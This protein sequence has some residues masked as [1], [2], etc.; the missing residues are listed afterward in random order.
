VGTLWQD[1]RYAFR[2]LRTHSGF[3][4]VAVLT[5]AL[6]IGANTAIFSVVNAVLLRPLPYADPGRLVTLWERSPRRGFEQE[7][8]TPP[9]FLDWREQ[10]RVFEN[11]AFWTGGGEFNLVTPD[12]V[13]KV[14]CAYALSNLFP[15]LRAGPLLGR[16]FL[17]EE[18]QRESNRV[19][20]LGYGYWQRR[21]AGDPSVIGRTITVDTYGRREY[22]IVGVMPP[23]FSFP[24][25]CEVWLPAGWNGIPTDR[26][27]GHWLEVIARLKPGVTL[28]QAQAEMN[29][30][31]A[32]LEQQYPDVLIGSQVAIVPLLEQT[33]GRNLRPALLVLWGVVAC[34]LLIACANVANL[35]LARAAVRRKEIAVRL[36]LGATRWQVI[37][38]L[39]TESVLLAMVGGVLGVLLA[40]WGLKVLV[41][42]G[43]N[44][45]PRLEGV[46]IDGR[47]L[48][49]TVLVS[50][51]TGVLFGLAPAWQASKPDVYETL[52]D[53]SRGMAGGL[54][55]SRLRSLLVV[56]E[57]ALSLVLLV[58]AGLMTRSFV[59]LIRIDRGFQPDHLLTAQLDFSISG[60]TTWVR[61]TATRPQ[62]TLQELMERIKHRPGVQS[63]AAV[64]WL[65]LTVGSARTQPIVIENHPPASSGD[66]LT[67]TFQGITPDY[68]RTLG[69]PLLAGRPFTES[70]VFEAPAVVIINETMAKRYFPNEN[71]VGQHL[72]MGGRTPG[73]IVGPNPNAR[74]PWSEIVGVVAD[75]KKLNLSAETVPEYYA[76]YWQ[77]PMQTPVIVVRTAADPANIAA[78][79]RGEVK[80]VNKNLPAPV[81]RTM[82]EI[83][84]D[85]VAQPRFH[86]LLV[87]LFG[88]VA[89]VL[90]ALGIY[91]VISYS[92]TQRTH[93]IGIRLALGA[94]GADILRLIVGQGM[95]LV[96]AGLLSGL[97]VASA[98]TRVMSGLLY[99][100]S[101]TDPATFA[102]TCLLLVGVALLA[103]YI[104]ARKAA[105][106]DPMIAL[107]HE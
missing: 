77:F 81:I 30:I 82:D 52:K 85:S 11:L 35:L 73:Q 75:M 51:L 23:G 96:A 38:Q 1:L 69:L 45:I 55:R 84:A 67:A 3:T 28:D 32:R 87:S 19:A 79:I 22:T 31:Q 44:H 68:F 72:A 14:K 97:A 13:E 74:S 26:R 100:V 9:D 71:P 65:P 57:V 46:S 70:D 8:V 106:V 66:P 95:T 21:F 91:G 10:S 41:A 93:E 58:G 34:V 7:R 24:N 107:R 40:L 98:L 18:D 42:I 39:L 48:V 4:V 104:P 88:A 101:A 54:H 17:P 60:F 63:V 43:A 5:L 62:V 50:L 78:A 49:F 12:G 6:G 25:R 99:G 27:G 102:G 53:S 47:S 56:L 83:L 33:L 20:V 37:R 89:L 59:R 61:P 29:A 103:C 80:A 15:M 76:S 86:T 16:T 64:S 36:A 94:Q 2:M 105:K 92:V 90:A